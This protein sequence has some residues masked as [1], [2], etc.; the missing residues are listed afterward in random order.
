MAAEQH[1]GENGFMVPAPSGELGA[2]DD[3]RE[4]QRLRK[5]RAMLGEALAAPE[6]CAAQPPA[7]LLT[8]A[9]AALPHAGAGPWATRQTSSTPEAGICGGRGG[10]SRCRSNSS[11]SSIAACAA[12]LRQP[13]MKL[14]TTGCGGADWKTYLARHPAQVKRR[15]RKGIPNALRS[16]AW[17]LLAG[18]RDLLLQNQGACVLAAGTQAADSGRLGTGCRERAADSLKLAA[19]G[20]EGRRHAQT[21]ERHPV[22]SVSQSPRWC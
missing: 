20:S 14:A 15:V 1:A 12:H 21:P 13:H 18:S 2:E 5:W 9:Q 16:M 10:R 17:Q 3:L 19:M 6:H 11:S 22:T 4:A 7:C 8:Q